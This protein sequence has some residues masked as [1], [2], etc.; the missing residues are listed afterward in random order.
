M[1]I[2]ENLKYTK[3]HEWVLIENNIATVGITDFAQGELGDIVY[4]EVDT[5]DETVAS[6][7]VFGTVEAVKTVSDLF[8]P[9]SG[10]IISF[11]DALTDTPELVNSDPYGQ[12]WMVKIEIENRDEIENLLNAKAYASIVQS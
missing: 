12:G 4:V 3:D 8:A 2:P 5:L 7:A 6:E 11:N 9:L 10:K 1:N